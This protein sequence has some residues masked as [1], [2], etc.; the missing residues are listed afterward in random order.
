MYKFSQVKYTRQGVPKTP[1]CDTAE[2]TDS[3]ITWQFH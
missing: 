3:R 2:F 1:A